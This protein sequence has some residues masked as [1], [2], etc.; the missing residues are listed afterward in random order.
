MVCRD[1]LR[2]E[3]LQRYTRDQGSAVYFPRAVLGGHDLYDATLT[4]GDC[5]LRVTLDP[6]LNPLVDRHVLQPGSTLQSAT[7][8]HAM[9][10]RGRGHPEDGHR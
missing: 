3:A 2:V 1:F 5:R 8:G 4:D 9:S 10:A 7:F 6:G